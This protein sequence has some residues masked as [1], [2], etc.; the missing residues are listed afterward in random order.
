MRQDFKIGRKGA[1]ITSILSQVPADRIQFD[2]AGLTLDLSGLPDTSDHLPLL[3]GEIYSCFRPPDAPVLQWYRIKPTIRGTI[4][5]PLDTSSTISMEQIDTTDEWFEGTGITPR[6]GRVAPLPIGLYVGIYEP[7]KMESALLK[8]IAS[9][10]RADVRLDDGTIHIPQAH[11]LSHLW[12]LGPQ[13][14]C[15]RPFA[16]EV[17]RVVKSQEGESITIDIA[18]LRRLAAVLPAKDYPPAVSFAMLMKSINNSL[19]PWNVQPRAWVREAEQPSLQVGWCDAERT[20]PSKIM[21]FLKWW[22][23][24]IREG[25][26]RIGRLDPDP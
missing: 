3:L 19:M 26:L 12:F 18:G 25:S 13:S 14:I 10:K 23:T 22:Q 15:A 17:A 9:T 6:F 5:M 21:A 11:G 16:R 8:L 7:D 2:A 24:S 1:E 20:P 4:G